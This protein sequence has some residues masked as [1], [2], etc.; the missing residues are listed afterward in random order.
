LDLGCFGPL[1]QKYIK[2]LNKIMFEGIGMVAISK[3]MFWGIFKVAWEELMTEAN[4]T[5]AFTKASI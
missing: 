3:R 4:I 1:S 5:F 2:G